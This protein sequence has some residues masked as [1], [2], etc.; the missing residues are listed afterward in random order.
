MK[1]TLV[2]SD[3]YWENEEKNLL[4]FT[5]LISPLKNKTNVIVLPEM[6]TTGF[7]MNVGKIVASPTG[8]AV[9]WLIQQAKNLNCVI[10]G[11]IAI[12]ENNKYYNR[13]FWVDPSGAVSTY[14]KRHLFRM[15]EEDQYYSAGNAKIIVE[16]NGLKF[17]PLI[18]Y[19]LRFPVWSRN[20]LNTHQYEYD[21][22]IYVANWPEVRNY[23]WQQLLIARAIENQCFVVGVNRV[24]VDGN[25]I[26]YCGNSMVVNPK[27]E[28]ITSLPK[29]EEHVV[30]VEIDKTNLTDF[31][32]KFPAI[33]DAD[34]F[35]LKI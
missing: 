13:L 32:K 9:K 29:N 17:L 5:E 22:L 15:G 30:T 31:R 18:C 25:D 3:L 27:G 14:N 19:D 35:L 34:N 6:F 8:N 20:T 7:S 23:P 21:I 24:G 12:T 26:N 1:I 4:H 33:L 28:I 10:C 2:Q 16:N 11:S